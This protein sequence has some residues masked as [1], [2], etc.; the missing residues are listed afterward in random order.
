MSSFSSPLLLFILICD[1][2]VLTVV[3][4]LF[5]WLMK[6]V[7]LDYVINNQWPDIQTR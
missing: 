4:I 1:S 2:Q 3:V 5:T 6:Q 7:D